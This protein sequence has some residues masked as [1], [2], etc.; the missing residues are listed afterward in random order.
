[1][2]QTRITLVTG[3]SR[4]GKSAHALSLVGA[5]NAGPDDPAA[6]VATCPVIDAE[7]QTRVARHQTERAGLGWETVEEETRLADA[8]RAIRATRPGR[9]IL[10]DSL[11]LWINNLMY[12]AQ[13]SGDA[14]SEDRVSELA[15]ELIETCRA[16]PGETILVT[17]EVGLGIIPENKSARLFRDLVGRCNQTIAAL[18]DVVTLV[19][20]GIPVAIKTAPAFNQDREPQ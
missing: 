9:T 18:A 16:T 2:Q 1:M 4:S 10:I 11:S 17:D 19:C 7:M 14:L 20:C 3:G 8:V 13:T 15:R 6:F 5:R 12:H